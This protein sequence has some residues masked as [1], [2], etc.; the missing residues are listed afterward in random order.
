MKFASH[1]VAW[2]VMKRKKP[3]IVTLIDTGKR[4][5]WSPIQ[6]VI[7]RVITFAVVR[8]VTH[9]YDYRLTSDGTK[10]TY[11]LIIKITIFEKHKK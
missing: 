8:F 11:Q 7:V 3:G 6:S 2:N 10:S 1:C 5:E 4:T 9:E